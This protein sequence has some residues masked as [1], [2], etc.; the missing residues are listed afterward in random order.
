VGVQVLR[1]APYS[2]EWGTSIFVKVVALNVYGSSQKS[3]EGN[4][5]VIT[6]YPD[7]PLNL[8]EVYE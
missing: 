6:T 5:A 3:L 4:G 1:D 8:A 7:A 2:L